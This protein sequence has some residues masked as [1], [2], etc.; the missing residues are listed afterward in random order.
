MSAGPA[1]RSKRRGNSRARSWGHAC[2]RDFLPGNP[3]QRAQ[4]DVWDIDACARKYEYVGSRIV[5]KTFAP[6]RV[7]DNPRN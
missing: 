2:E 7:D 3:C 6:D 4:R 5:L 1:Y